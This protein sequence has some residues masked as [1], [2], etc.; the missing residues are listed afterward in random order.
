MKFLIV[1]KA[2]GTVRE[3]ESI[4]VG[5]VDQEVLGE[6]SNVQNAIQLPSSKG[7]GKKSY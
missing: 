2:F 1:C 5:P 4:S 3:K 6:L 7:R